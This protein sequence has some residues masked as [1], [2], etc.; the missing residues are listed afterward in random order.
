MQPAD[1][2]P[3]H[4]S[5][6][7]ADEYI[8]GLLDAE[9]AARIGQHS[10][11]CAIC[12]ARLDDAGGIAGQ[13][14]LAAPIHRAPPQLKLRVLR[15]AGIVRQPAWRRVLQHPGAVA[16]AVAVIIALG[17]LAG[18]L[19]LQS[20]VDDLKH[21]NS[22]LRA[23]LNNSGN[24]SNQALLTA[25]LSPGSVMAPIVST[26]S[27]SPPAGRLVWNDEQQKCWLVFD[28]LPALPPG[29]TYQLWA[30]SEGTFWSL[31][32]FTTHKTGVIQYTADVSHDIADYTSAVVTVEKAGGSDTM[33]GAPIYRAD[34]TTAESEYQ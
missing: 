34:L 2:D 26:K 5:E 21:D 6:E 15:E 14:A 27:G 29:E 33:T 10:A 24:S 13:I 1:A 25:L 30:D 4:I 32:A 12:Q 16:A 18:V 28:K 20:Q 17:S 8:L 22:Q 11:A 23:Q 19:L 3:G 31:G 9:T 7:D